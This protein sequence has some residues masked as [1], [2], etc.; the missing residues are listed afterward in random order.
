MKNIV[1]NKK[2]TYV[3]ILTSGG[4]DSTACINFYKKLDFDIDSVFIDYGQKAKIQEYKAAKL[5]ADF[6]NV[7]LRII[8]LK[9]DKKMKTG[10]ILGR[11]AFLIFTALLN[12]ERNKGIISLGLHD[13]TPYYDCSKLFFEQAQIIISSYSQGM[14]QLNCPFL[15]FNKK[16]I[17]DYCLLEKAPLELCY[18]CESGNKKPCGKCSTCKDLKIIYA[19]TDKQN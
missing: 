4:I 19:S 9:S 2:K 7:N 8:K 18:S 13:G 15:N 17:Y 12:F 6:Y 3:V 5:I 14:I 10:E 16:E 11:N 1:M